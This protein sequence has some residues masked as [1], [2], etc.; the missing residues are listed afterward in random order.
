M[1]FGRISGLQGDEACIE[2][3]WGIANAEDSKQRIDVLVSSM[4]PL[5]GL[6]PEDSRIY[7]SDMLSEELRTISAGCPPT[8]TTVSP[9]TPIPGIL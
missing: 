6:S 5:T 7:V 1:V 9:I 3:V 4:K 8:L 2:V